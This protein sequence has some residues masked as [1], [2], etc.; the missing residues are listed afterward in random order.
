MS[1]SIKEAKLLTDEQVINLHDKAAEHTLIGTQ[2]YLDELARRGQD[3]VN[4]EMLK[5]TRIMLVI[6]ILAL[7]ISTGALLIALMPYY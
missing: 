5:L 7:V 2:F 1:P 6:T 4:N 3:K